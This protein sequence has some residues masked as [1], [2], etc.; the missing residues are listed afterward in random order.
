MKTAR[1]GRAWD[2][3]GNVDERRD[4]IMRGLNTVLRAR[5]PGP[6]RMQDVADHLGLVKGN[7]YYYFKSKEELIYH[8]HVKCVEV[9]LAALERARAS[10]APP[11]ERLRTLMVEHILAMTEG[12]YGGVL[13]EDIEKLTPARRRKYVALRDAFERGVRDLIKSGI[14]SGDFQKQDAR[15][16]GFA[17]LGAINWIPKWYRPGGELSAQAIADRF[18]DLFVRALRP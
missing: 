14:A 2:A 1:K 17:I 10:K 7:L 16:A 11:A 15:T 18:A 12:E 8:A 3:A 4:A 13:L 6:L 9:S 5:S